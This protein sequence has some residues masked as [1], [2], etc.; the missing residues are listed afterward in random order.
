MINCFWYR[1]TPAAA[2]SVKHKQSI[3]FV[4]SIGE[5]EFKGI[6]KQWSVTFFFLYGGTCASL[7]TT[8]KD[9]CLYQ[10]CYSTTTNR[11]LHFS[12]L[13]VYAAFYLYLYAYFSGVKHLNA[14]PPISIES[15]RTMW[16]VLAKVCCLYATMVTFYLCDG[17]KL[18]GVDI[19]FSQYFS[20]RKV[21]KACGVKGHLLSSSSLSCKR[22]ASGATLNSM[23]HV[24][25]FQIPVAGCARLRTREARYDHILDF[26]TWLGVLSSG[27]TRVSTLCCSGS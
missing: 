8:R 11:W 20:L 4:T 16:I 19:K 18:F 15:S 26:G 27:I 2:H 1:E 12:V 5:K 6:L 21:P 13:V 9:C 3:Y 17:A 25:Q 14:E 23:T 24:V 10:V 7:A 22:N